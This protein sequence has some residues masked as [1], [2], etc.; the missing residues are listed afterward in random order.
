MSPVA[1]SRKKSKTLE[2]S[3]ARK[4]A[5]KVATKTAKSNTKTSRKKKAVKAGGS[6]TKKLSAKE[7][8]ASVKREPL[9]HLI[10]EEKLRE[11]GFTGTVSS[12]KELLEKYATDES[13]F[14]IE[15]QIVVQPKTKE[16]V[17]IAVKVFSE[18]TKKFPALSLT[19]RAA[20]TG[21]SGGSLTDSVVIDV[22]TH[23]N[24]IE[25]VG[26]AG[27]DVLFICEPGAMW[28]D[29]EK[30]LA[31]FD[32]YIAPYPASK[33]ICTIGGAV[34]NNA[35]GPDSLRYGQVA[36]WIESLDVVLHDGKTYTIEALDYD[37]YKKLI[38]QKTLLAEIAKKIFTLIEKNEKIIK[39]AEPKTK[40][41]SAG[42]ALWD[43]VST[44]VADFKKGKGVFDMTRLISGSQG[45]LGIITSITMRARKKTHDTTFIVAPVFELKDASNVVLEA[46]K[47]DPI[48]VEMFDGLTF[49]MALQNPEFFKRR[50]S[51]LDYYKVMLT[52]YMTYHV[53]FN[54]KTPE[55]NLLI[56]LDNE[57]LGDKK[58][59]E[60]VQKLRDLGGKKTR[61]V[62]GATE[63]EM[64]WQLR[65]ASYMLA[66][67]KD[68]KKRPAPFLE[69]IT[70]PPKQMTGF[71][72]EIKKF[73]K[74]YNLIAAVHGHG[75]NGHFHFYPLMDFENRTTPALIVKMAEEFFTTAVKHGG[76]LCGEHN[77]GIIRTPHLSKMF[78]KNA[79]QLFEQVE[80]IFDPDDIF[81]PG[82]KVHPRF[83]V[84]SSIRKTN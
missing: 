10:A 5:R 12:E 69:D 58:P 53:A 25:N 9:G 63:K 33:D 55:F 61:V 83:D 45:S 43:V 40:K 62:R 64:W 77:D 32:A 50:L 49:D 14:H 26:Y 31:R 44:S 70:V 17:E 22:I 41:N 18:A 84:K 82:K 76:N 48:N 34:A 1:T 57:T 3:S 11:A 39:R 15:P 67:L 52:M 29:V 66:K 35:A 72:V 37:Q 8:R 46:L 4:R 80:S 60:I 19:P 79:L 74:K 38:K 73:L 2:V 6:T 30:E 47:Y 51:G 54:K 27:E 75:G 28:K 42:Y 71:F 23:L 7:L 16:D 24:Q 78:S 68:P 56:T 20:G 81:N 65:R 36:D 21:L 59:A 13:I